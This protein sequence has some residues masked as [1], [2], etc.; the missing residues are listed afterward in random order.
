MVWTVTTTGDLPD[1]HECR[2]HPESVAAWNDY[3]GRILE[4]EVHGYGQESEGE[5]GRRWVC[6]LRRGAERISVT[7]ERTA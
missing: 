6:D 4:L 7:I 1:E 5:Y 3:R 2:D